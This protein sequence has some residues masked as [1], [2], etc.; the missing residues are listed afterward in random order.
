VDIRKLLDRA[1]SKFITDKIVAHI[2]ADQKRFNSLITIFLAG[3]YR[4]TQRAAWPL[5]YCVKNHPF[6]ID[7]H[8]PS[9]LKMAVKPDAHVAVKRNIVRLLQFVEVPDS[10]E[11]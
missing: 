2:G 6:L 8:Y 4:I 9:I 7:R 3:P 11:R 5:S 1:H 10:R